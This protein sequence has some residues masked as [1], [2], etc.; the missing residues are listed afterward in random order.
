M[1][2]T[3]KKHLAYMFHFTCGAFY[4]NS[5]GPCKILA[6]TQLQ[7][8]AIEGKL[9]RIKFDEFTVDDA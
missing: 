9:E 6:C 7:Y 5:Y 4:S 2:Y 3:C 1:L 8:V